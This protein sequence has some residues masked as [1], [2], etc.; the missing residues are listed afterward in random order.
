MRKSSS[1]FI[2][3]VRHIFL[4]NFYANEPILKFLDVYESWDFALSETLVSVEFWVGQ[5]SLNWRRKHK[6]CFCTATHTPSPHRNRLQKSM[7]TEN[8]IMG[9]MRHQHLYKNFTRTKFGANPLKNKDYRSERKF[10]QNN[11]GFDLLTNK[12]KVMGA[13]GFV[14]GVTV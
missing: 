3:K 5:S 6:P 7:N 10:L 14:A 11:W 2:I 9:L 12:T 13:K 4:C 8:T 1:F